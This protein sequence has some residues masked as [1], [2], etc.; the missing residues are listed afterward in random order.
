MFLYTI[1]KNVYGLENKIIFFL[2]VDP[3]LLSEA[4]GDMLVT[5]IPSPNKIEKRKFQP[6]M[7]FNLQ[8]GSLLVID[9][10]MLEN[11]RDATAR[12]VQDGSFKQCG[13]VLLVN[14][15][16]LY[17]SDKLTQMNLSLRTLWSSTIVVIK[18]WNG[19]IA[20]VEDGMFP[21]SSIPHITDRISQG[22]RRLPKLLRTQVHWLCMHK[23]GK[24]VSNG[25]P[26]P[27]SPNKQLMLSTE[28]DTY[29]RTVAEAT[30]T[31]A[32]IS[33]APAGPLVVPLAL[34][35][36]PVGLP[37]FAPGCSLFRGA[38]WTG[39]GCHKSVAA[40]AVAG[41]P[42]LTTLPLLCMHSK[43]TWVLNNLGSLLIPW[44][45]LSAM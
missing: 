23:S 43:Q 24:V 10:S 15:K 18:P 40:C 16:T 17:S 3:Q 32:V 9:C 44:L 35:A 45:I 22:I 29:L 38:A 26:A 1:L 13:L 20:R 41:G 11:L 6:G 30:T 19:G 8:A 36:T 21:T 2:V 7:F 37:L 4:G 5:K 14:T 27:P 34:S 33:A 31:S 28:V 42:L 25:P 39:P 12:A